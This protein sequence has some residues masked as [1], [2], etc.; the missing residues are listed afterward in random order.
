MSL[1]KKPKNIHGDTY[2]YSKVEEYVN[3]HTKVNIIC[4]KHEFIFPIQPNNHINKK[5]TT[6]LSKMW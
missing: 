2:D 5:K 3:N 1:F 4:L 6:R